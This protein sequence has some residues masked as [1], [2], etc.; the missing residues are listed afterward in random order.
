MIKAINGSPL[1][2]LP[3]HRTSVQSDKWNVH[4]NDNTLWKYV[5]TYAKFIYSAIRSAQLIQDGDT[6][7]FKLPM[8]PQDVERGLALLEELDVPSPEEDKILKLHSFSFPLLSA[9]PEEG[10]R[11]TKWEDP[12]QAFLAILFVRIDGNFAPPRGVTPRLS[13]CKYILRNN[14]FYQAYMQRS[15]FGGDLTK[16]VSILQESMTLTDYK[17]IGQ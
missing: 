4:E 6:D 2:V 9:C 11:A 10:H 13:H 8:S 17:P 5:E 15:S 3:I 7:S 14:T 12:L 1:N 16:Y